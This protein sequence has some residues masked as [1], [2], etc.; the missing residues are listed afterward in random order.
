[1]EQTAQIYLDFQSKAASDQFQIYR[2]EA[3]EEISRPYRYTLYL[4]SSA[5]TLSSLDVQDVL[6]QPAHLELRHPLPGSSD[7]E[8]LRVPGM[9]ASLEVMGATKDWAFYRVELVPRVWKMSLSRQTR[10]FLDV[11]M[12][13]IIEKVLQGVGFASE[14]YELR[15][16][17]SYAKREFVLQFQESDLDFLSR[18]MEH[19]GIFYFFEESD[20]H[21]K[22]VFGDGTQAYAKVSAHSALEYNPIEGGAAVGRASQ[23]GG[24]WIEEEQVHE[25]ILRHSVIPKK[26]ILNDYDDQ[27][28]SLGLTSESDVDS[29]G[30]A[31]VYDYPGGFIDPGEGGRLAKIRAEEFRCAQKN[32]L[33]KTNCRAFRAGYVFALK[34]YHAEYDTEYLIVRARHEGSQSAGKAG[35]GIPEGA[36]YRNEFSALPAELSFRPP[37]RTPVP[38]VQGVFTGKV[39]AAGDGQYAEIDD[40]GRY[41][42]KLAWDLSDKKDGKASSY[43]RMAQPY[44][45]PNYGFHCPL[46][47]GVEVLVGFLNGDPD[48]PI[49]I[50]SIPN[51]ETGS[52]VVGG[53]HTQCVLLSGG[54]N[55][56]RFDDT[57]G[58]EHVYLHGQKDWNIKIE[59]DKTQSVGH[60]ETLDVGNN[61]T[62]TVGADQSET[63]GKNKTTQVGVNHTETIGSNQTINVGANK[64][65]TVGASSSETV[66]AAKMVAIGGAFQIGVAGA[67]NETVGA[68]KA[69][70]VGGAVMESVGGSAGESVGGGKS[71]SVGKDFTVT[72]GGSHTEKVDKQ[73]SVVAKDSVQVES[74]KDVVLKAGSASITLKKNGDIIIQGKDITIKA[75][76]GVS[77]KASKD[78]ALKGSKV[79]QN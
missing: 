30:V 67:M 29:D 68:A 58:S 62:K 76:G 32:I 35:L 7:Y 71:T 5:D 40:Q 15:L 22:I 75:S 11:A 61:R 36:S 52:P 20:D 12:P 28:P 59:N 4:L 26:V 77:A 23:E 46:H 10:I 70:E 21:D 48:R 24:T 14:D 37:R 2:F 69:S 39:D 42:V 50:G 6:R 55:E 79:L 64:S 53:N 17:A 1:M 56:F 38:I 44:A 54:N 74:S 9:V 43:L 13:E 3:T 60:D 47:K 8:T 66:G 72:V 63:I 31:E 73:Y 49:I 78:V 57:K 33:G 34:G 19:E 51:P 25:L 16:S 45:G 27:K 41:K 18:L 65:E